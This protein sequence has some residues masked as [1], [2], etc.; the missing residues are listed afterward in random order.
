[1][2]IGGIKFTHSHRKDTVSVRQDAPSLELDGDLT[3]VGDAHDLVRAALIKSPDDSNEKWLYCESEAKAAVA[4][5]MKQSFIARFEDELK[6]IAAGLSKPRGRKKYQKVV[7][8][9]GRLKEKQKAN[10]GML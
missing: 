2:L 1:M 3:P 10:F 5:Q 8:R 4:S 6:K 7:E 9:I